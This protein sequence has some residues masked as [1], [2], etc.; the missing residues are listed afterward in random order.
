MRIARHVVVAAVLVC[1][2][3]SAQAQ[4]LGY[5]EELFGSRRSAFCRATPGRS[6]WRPRFATNWRAWARRQERPAW[7]DDVHGRRW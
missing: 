4:T 6:K 5:Q 2:A 1:L 7:W 3:I